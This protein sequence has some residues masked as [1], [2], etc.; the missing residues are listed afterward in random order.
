[1]PV[2]LGK[3][4]H[5][6][7]PSL[8]NSGNGTATLNDLVGSSNHSLVNAAWLANTENGGV[9]AISTNGSEFYAEGEYTYANAITNPSSTFA[10]SCWFKASTFQFA[11]RTIMACSRENDTG[12]VWIN[13][14]SG[15]SLQAIFQN[16]AGSNATVASSANVV[17]GAW[18][19]VY[20][21]IESENSME[22][23]VDGISTGA[24]SLA[25]GH[26]FPAGMNASLGGF[27]KDPA[28]SSNS[29]IGLIDDA[30]I[31]NSAL[32]AGEI[33]HFSATR[34][35]E[36]G[37]S[38]S[39]SL[40]V[41]ELQ[42]ISQ[43]QPVLTTGKF[44]AS[45]D[46]AESVSQSS[47]ANIPKP[48][49]PID[50]DSA[51]SS[52]NISEA[53]VEVNATPHSVQSQPECSEFTLAGKAFIGVA[54]SEASAQNQ[55]VLAGLNTSIDVD[56]ASSTTLV[57]RLSLS[58]TVRVTGAEVGICTPG[59]LNES[60]DSA[61][62][63]EAITRGQLITVSNN[64]FAYL[65]SAL[66]L[67][68]S[69]Y[70]GF[71]LTDADQ[72]EVVAYI[73]E[74]DIILGPVLEANTLYVAGTEPGTIR[75]V[76]G[77]S[78]GEYISLVG[79]AISN[80]TLRITTDVQSLLLTENSS[81]PATGAVVNPDPDDIKLINTNVEPQLTSG[82]VSEAINKG[83]AINRSRSKAAASGED[84]SS[85]A[86]VAFT[87]S[88]S[89]CSSGVCMRGD[90]SFGAGMFFPNMIYVVS[91]TP[92]LLMP[93]TEWQKDDY[94]TIAGIAISESVIRLGAIPKSTPSV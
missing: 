57:S 23:W 69:E 93:A 49:I 38:I 80:T 90:V 83:D 47:D 10:M 36:G 78:S 42:S 94:A 84:A 72:G 50:V 12:H 8:D 68:L 39:H 64:G 9:R 33:S 14:T 28:S 26:T 87:S 59:N 32:T 85:F 20:L 5:W 61:V 60:V 34:G 55:A 4:T 65:S 82:I 7:C 27:V 22:I 41:D 88:E 86:G 56:S 21:L 58:E 11:T 92:G 24:Q 48:P 44:V 37:P 89:G 30:R 62:A 18:H 2:G 66:S 43:C 15:N 53:N 46:N 77:I 45:V 19:H 76:T 70:T 35:I 63:G 74:G 54:G 71:A 13:I 3:E 31:F 52:S 17:D 51:K 67:S 73:E 79:L 40:T 6:W 25:A 81:S 29:Y 16:A 91:R 1:M 75:D